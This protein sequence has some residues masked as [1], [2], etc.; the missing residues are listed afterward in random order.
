MCSSDLCLFGGGRV[1][2]NAANPLH[3]I[4]LNEIHLAALRAGVL[5]RW[6]SAMEIRSQNELTEFGFA[7]DYD[8]VVTVIT[9]QGERRFALEYERSPKAAKSYRAIAACISQ[10]AHVGRLLYLVANYD[11][12]R[13]VSGFFAGAK[14]PVFF[15]LVTDW[16]A[17]LL[18]MPVL[19]GHAKRTFPLQRALNGSREEGQ[20]PGTAA[21][22]SLPFH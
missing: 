13:F 22:Y 5:V 4:G 12:L 8:A 20:A 10:E 11:I 15:G 6:T 16:H 17:R 2:A 9:G 14:F 21:S 3:A 18:E 19:D 1:D 7:K